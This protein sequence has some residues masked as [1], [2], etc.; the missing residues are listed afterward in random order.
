MPECALPE[1][2]AAQAL[3]KICTE[4]FASHK[5]SPVRHS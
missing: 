3:E 2:A 1:F 4:E 5:S